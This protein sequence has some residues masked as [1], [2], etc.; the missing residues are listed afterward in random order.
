MSIRVGY[1]DFIRIFRI[2]D[3]TKW[4]PSLQVREDG[5]YVSEPDS[6]L[7]SSEERAVLTEH[8]TGDLTQPALQFPC[9]IDELKVFVN[10]FGLHGYIDA[11]DLLKIVERRA[12]EE[13]QIEMSE[14]Q[15][16]AWPIVVKIS[17]LRGRLTRSIEVERKRTHPNDSKIVAMREV[18][19]ELNTALPDPEDVMVAYDS[20]TATPPREGYTDPN[21]I[22]CLVALM[23]SESPTGRKHSVFNSQGAIIE[24]LL[25]NYSGVKGLSKRNLEMKIAAGRLSAGLR[26]SRD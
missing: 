6:L 22:A 7:I 19:D 13:A 25:S 24:A 9:G 1:A 15:G 3:P 21:V 4:V 18:L 8:P 10:F 17:A 11:F 26:P 20:L 23:L 16:Y 2:E 14:S 5:V 12:F